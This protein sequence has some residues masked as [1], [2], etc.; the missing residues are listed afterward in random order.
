[1]PTDNSNSELNGGGNIP[2]PFSCL[3]KEPLMKLGEGNAPILNYQLPSSTTFDV[4]G[5]F[6]L[7]IPRTKFKEARLAKNEFHVWSRA[8]ELSYEQILHEVFDVFHGIRGKFGLFLNQNLL[9]GVVIPY[10][11]LE[12]PEVKYKEIPRNPPPRPRFEE[13]TPRSPKPKPRTTHSNT[14]LSPRWDNPYQIAS[15]IQEG[16]IPF[17]FRNAY[18]QIDLE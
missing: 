4:K 14:S 6:P 8:K 5:I 15:Y 10:E 9:K 13:P 7:H 2:Q 16:F 1:M 3:P 11:Q 12:E 17:V 18:G